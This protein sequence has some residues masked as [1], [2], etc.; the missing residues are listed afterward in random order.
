MQAPRLGVKSAG[1]AVEAPGPL[2]LRAEIRLGPP[3]AEEQAAS[4]EFDREG[5]GP[6]GRKF[7]HPVGA[8][9][10]GDEGAKAGVH[11]GRPETGI[12]IIIVNQ[13]VDQPRLSARRSF[14][15]RTRW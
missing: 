9:G 8:F 4:I 14:G 15:Y 12:S 10:S 13:K 5:P 2:R 6:G 1:L 7:V 3:D 11:D